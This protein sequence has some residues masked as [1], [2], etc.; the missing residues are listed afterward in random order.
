MF[1]RICQTEVQESLLSI[2]SAYVLLRGC[3]N[4]IFQP[5]CGG[6]CGS[7]TTSPAT[8]LTTPASPQTRST[9]WQRQ[10]RGAIQ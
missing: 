2:R 8:F 9:S 3:V 4:V 5:C 7:A 10:H 1:E 6:T